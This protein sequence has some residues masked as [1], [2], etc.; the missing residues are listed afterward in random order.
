MGDAG[1]SNLE[2]N[3]VTEESKE[4]DQKCRD[5]FNQWYWKLQ[6]EK[7]KGKTVPKGIGIS[8]GSFNELLTKGSFRKCNDNYHKYVGNSS[9]SVILGD[10]TLRRSVGI[11]A[12]LSDVKIEYDDADDSDDD[13][14]KG[15]VMKMSKRKMWKRL[16]N[17]MKSVEDTSDDEVKES[18][19][20]KKVKEDTSDEEQFKEFKRLKNKRKKDAKKKREVHDDD[21]L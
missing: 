18:K 5:D 6:E 21:G 15:L 10:E 3:V 17:L 16:K 9:G 2:G 13:A 20:R 4:V 19:K 12:S 14:L 11:Q 1:K 7:E 8:D